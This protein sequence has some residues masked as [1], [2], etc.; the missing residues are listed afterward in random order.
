MTDFVA[1]HSLSESGVIR[2]S[3]KLS[4]Q[5]RLPHHFLS[6]GHGDGGNS[7]TDT[8]PVGALAHDD[9][10]FGPGSGDHLWGMTRQNY[11]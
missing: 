9:D 7:A 8:A 6:P 4:G 10:I 1:A 5:P 2:H 11:L 3:G